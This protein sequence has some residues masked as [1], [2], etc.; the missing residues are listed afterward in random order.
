MSAAR[1][2]EEAL[3]LPP[4]EREELA[5]KLVDSLD[6]SQIVPG[7]KGVPLDEVRAR[8]FSK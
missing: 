8:L 3:A 6:A 2:L 7:V 4:S 1:I 5:A